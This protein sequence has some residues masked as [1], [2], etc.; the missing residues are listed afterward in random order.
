MRS[1]ISIPETRVQH[2]ATTSR[3]AERSRKVLEA[4]NQSP[5]RREHSNRSMRAIVADDTRP[6]FRSRR[7]EYI[8]PPLSVF[9]AAQSRRP[10]VYVY[11]HRSPAAYT[12]LS[13]RQH[14]NI[15]CCLSIGLSAAV[16]TTTSAGTCT[17]P[18]ATAS[19]GGGRERERERGR[20]P[21]ACAPPPN[22]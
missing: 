8:A 13:L 11:I 21:R 2:C 16:T 20:N 10:Y 9:P 3:R 17:R 7:C 5:K 15:L 14:M 6:R 18:R 4:V 1:G 12:L 19:E 22:D